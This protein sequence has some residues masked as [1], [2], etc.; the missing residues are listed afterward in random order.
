[1]L[2]IFSI[3]AAFY[4][5]AA[6]YDADDAGLFAVCHLEIYIYIYIYIYNPKASFPVHFSQALLA[7]KGTAPWYQAGEAGKSRARP[8]TSFVS[9]PSAAIAFEAC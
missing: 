1:M 9:E 5:K 7:A 4:P 3:G 2:K 6:V 8:R